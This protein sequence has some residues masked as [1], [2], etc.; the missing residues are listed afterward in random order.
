MRL[1]GAAVA[2]VPARLWSPV[3]NEAL[4]LCHFGVT[5]LQC[6]AYL[7]LQKILE[8]LLHSMVGTMIVVWQLLLGAISGASGWVRSADGTPR[9]LS[10]CM[11]TA[12]TSCRELARGR[13]SQAR[14]SVS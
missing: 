4:D 6:P 9:R 7:P 5:L 3:G 10:T 2:G 11:S 14:L 12:C 13:D 8:A 1:S